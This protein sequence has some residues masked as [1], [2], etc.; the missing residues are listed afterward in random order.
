MRPEPVHDDLD[1]RIA[2]AELAV[3]ERDERIRRRT[4]A[5]VRRA[6]SDVARHAGTGLALGAG[7][8]AFVW[9]LR[10]ERR[11]Q[12]AAEPAAAPVPPPAGPGLW[13]T[14]A[15]ELG[16]SLT[17]LL[18]MIWPYMPRALRR[19]VQPQTAAAM[20]G[21]LAPFVAR[22]LRRSPRPRAGA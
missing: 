22:L 9:W 12:A 3:I 16:L 18:P 15:R 4:H 21:V 13:E 1:A 20:L 11:G 10:R 17:S 6:K 19:H 7:L 8:A 14:L 5:V 2:R